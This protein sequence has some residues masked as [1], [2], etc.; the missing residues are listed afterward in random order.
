MLETQRLILPRPDDVEDL[1]TALL[2]RRV[3]VKRVK[4]G[5][6]VPCTG[7]IGGYRDAEGAL[8]AVIYA[9][10]ESVNACGGALSMIPVG[11]VEDANEEFEITA[12]IADNFKEILNIM[13][14]LFNDKR[15]RAEHVRFRDFSLASEEPE[16]LLS[17][18]SQEK[19]R[20]D[21][22][23]TVSGGYG[24]KGIGVVL[25]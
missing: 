10:L 14:G 2:G 4:P 7:A 21:V 20:M 9:E 12:T 11:G 8:R 18:V 13:A 24:G 17:F 22:T 5:D 6:K 15:Q 23:V 1:L 19:D 25:V 3:D 16:D